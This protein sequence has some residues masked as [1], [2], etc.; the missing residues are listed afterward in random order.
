MR[1]YLFICFVLMLFVSG[2][3]KKEADIRRVVVDVKE[4]Q[5]NVPFSQLFDSLAYIPL[6]TTKESLFKQI[7][8]LCMDKEG[9]FYILDQEGVNAIY[10][11]DKQGRFKG[12]IGYRGKGPREYLEITDFC[13]YRDTIVEIYDADR[14]KRM[15]YTTSG[16][17]IREE[18][19]WDMGGASF[20][21]WGDT[22]AF[23]GSCGGYCPNLKVYVDGK[24][25]SFFKQDYPEMMDKWEY[26]HTDGSSLYYS[27]NYNDT[28]YY[29]KDGKMDPYFYVDFGEQKLPKESRDTRKA[30]ESGLCFEI[31][32]VKFISNCVYFN[33]KYAS[34]VIHTF[35]D[36]KRNIVNLV[37]SF[38][39]DIDGVPFFI[40]GRVPSCPDKMVTYLEAHI[41]MSIYK[42]YQK[43]GEKISEAYESLAKQLTEDSNP[44]IF[45]AYIKK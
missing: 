36:R 11:F 20:I 21:H 38:D 17:F 45:F 10:K 9:N 29:F 23:Y 35:W 34:R 37:R 3:T 18:N 44:V 6:E 2:C 27:D 31:D 7:D 39:N 14:E 26:F 16:K 42:D 25:H 22:V 12:Q 41:I 4:I 32:N 40:Q 33:F 13:L 19:N 5:K 24:K 28:L 15:Q 1:K 30:M 43:R 8:K